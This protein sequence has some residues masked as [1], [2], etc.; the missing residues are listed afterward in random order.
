M[1]TTVLINAPYG[2]V[3]V[4]ANESFKTFLGISGQVH[5]QE[6]H[7]QLPWH[8]LSAGIAGALASIVTQPL[9]VI[10]TRLQTQD[11]CFRLRTT[12]VESADAHP[13]ARG[14][15]NGCVDQRRNF[16]MS[17][18]HVPR[19]SGFFA[20]ASSIYTQEGLKGFCK[21]MIP[22]MIQAVPSAAMCWGTY[23]TLKAILC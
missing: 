8:F 16:S 23:E 14:V 3:L 2:G 6:M 5:R 13:S 15:A 18:Q 1:P 9:D 11:V 21:G 10:K 12:S 7:S 19:Y 4:A 17:S 20:V 22:R